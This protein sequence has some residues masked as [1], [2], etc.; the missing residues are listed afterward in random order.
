[1]EERRSMEKMA[2]AEPT[3]ELATSSSNRTPLWVRMILGLLL[4]LVL[5]AIAVH[6]A[7]FAQG[8]GPVSHSLGVG[9]SSAHD[10][11]T[12]T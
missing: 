6:V 5:A 3:S 8:H 1:M 12:A 10:A 11:F 4:V 2:G 7:G 9:D